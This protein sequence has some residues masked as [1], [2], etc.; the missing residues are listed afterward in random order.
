M[1][2]NRSYHLMQ[3]RDFYNLGRYCSMSI[4]QGGNGLPF[5]AEQVYDYL[6]VGKS[7]GLMIDVND[8]PG[9]ILQ[10]VIQKVKLT[11]KIN[12]L[13]K[14]IVPAGRIQ[15]KL[16]ILVITEQFMALPIGNSP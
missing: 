8:V 3:A 4:C 11:H 5:M 7:A 15:G 16:Y 9:H 1:L 12:T 6:S 2:V 10:F 14:L 13:G